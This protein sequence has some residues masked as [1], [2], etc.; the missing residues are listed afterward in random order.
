M[1]TDE[2]AYSKFQEEYEAAVKII[3]KERNEK[4]KE[5]CRND[6][7]YNRKVIE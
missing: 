3:T 1:V 4:V 6:T 2:E 7:E 5:R